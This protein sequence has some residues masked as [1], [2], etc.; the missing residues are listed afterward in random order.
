MTTK[1]NRKK[2][3]CLPK[4]VQEKIQ[5]EKELRKIHQWNIKNDLKDTEFEV[6]Y[7]KQKTT[8]IISSKKLLER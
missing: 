6:K 1:K 7:K 3:F 8:P 5:K 2:R 4:E